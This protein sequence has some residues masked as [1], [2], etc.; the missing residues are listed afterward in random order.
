METLI[1]LIESKHPMTK[2]DTRVLNTELTV[3][4]SSTRS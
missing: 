2:F 1:Q 4:A 3:R